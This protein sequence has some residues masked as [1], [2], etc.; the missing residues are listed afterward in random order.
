MTRSFN[1]FTEK[2]V[3][4]SFF[5][6]LKVET[7][8]PIAFDF[9]F[10]ADAYLHTTCFYGH[11][12][13]LTKNERGGVD[14]RFVPSPLSMNIKNGFCVHFLKNVSSSIMAV[15]DNE[16]LRKMR[17]IG[18]LSKTEKEII[19]L[20]EENPFSDSYQ[21]KTL[22]LFTSKKEKEKYLLRFSRS[23]TLQNELSR[24]EKC[25]QPIIQYLLRMFLR[26]SVTEKQRRIADFLEDYVV[27]IE[28]HPT[29]YLKKNG[30]YCYYEKAFSSFRRG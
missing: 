25:N 10:S 9:F 4:P 28:R 29:L 18:L 8:R 1:V 5:E 17:D 16:L 7:L 23:L 3:D 12:H 24:E 19:V 30:N 13:H 22:F 6:A 15:N 14:I 2:D 11:V 27:T 21:G 26:L 20:P